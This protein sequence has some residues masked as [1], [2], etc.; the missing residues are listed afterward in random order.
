MHR[1]KLSTF[2]IDCEGELEAA[3]RFWSAALGRRARAPSEG[4]D[5]YRDLEAAPAEPLLMIQAVD[6]P[7]RVHLDIESDDIE[8]EVA[9]LERLGARRIEKVRTWVVMQA[10]TGQRFC[11]VRPQRGEL[12][13]SATTW[14]SSAAPPPF[15]GDRHHET[16]RRLVGRYGG[17]TRLWLDPT[18]PPGESLTELAIDPVAGGGFIRISEHGTAAGTPHAGEM[19]VGYHA[20]AGRYEA[21]WVDS[22]HTAGGILVST[23]APRP[24]DVIAVT[25]SYTAAGQTWGWRTEISLSDEALTIRAFNVLPTGQEAPAIETICPRRR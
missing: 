22:F 20:E 3:T 5:R 9:R 23:G 15:A 11:V 2:V 14:P 25:G 7:G 1:S 21:S 4:D 8:A 19:T 16:L 13:L 18:R 6:H 10:P 24:D 17:Q 12:G